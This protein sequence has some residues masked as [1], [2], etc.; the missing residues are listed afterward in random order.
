[1]SVRNRLSNATLTVARNLRWGI[2]WALAFAVVYLVWVTV[3]FAMGGQAAFARKGVTFQ[4][5]ILGYLI[6]ALLGGTLLGLLRPLNRWRAGSALTGVIVGGAI[7]CTLMLALEPRSEIGLYIFTAVVFGLMGGF[8]AFRWSAP[9]RSHS[10]ER[11]VETAR[12][13]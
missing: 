11:E 2:G 9:E 3:L 7:G 4:S 8:I 13:L 12:R 10:T 6:S 5:T 1:M